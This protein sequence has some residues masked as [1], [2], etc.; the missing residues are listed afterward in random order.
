MIPKG[1]GQLTRGTL[2]PMA[3]APA[4]QNRAAAPFWCD[5]ATCARWSMVARSPALMAATVADGSARRQPRWAG[6]PFTSAASVTHLRQG[7][8]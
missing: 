1:R 6:S 5:S 2:T 3:A 4:G 7:R 8:S